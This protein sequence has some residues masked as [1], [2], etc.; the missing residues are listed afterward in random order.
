MDFNYRE[1]FPAETP[2][3]YQRLL[4]DCMLGDQMLFTRHDAVILAW[5]LLAHPLDAWQNDSAPLHQYPAGSSTFPAADALI[6]RDG[7]SWRPL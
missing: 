4:L 7:R 6:Q 3:A 2:D 5:K 1:V